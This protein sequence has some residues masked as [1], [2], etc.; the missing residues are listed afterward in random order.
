VGL[1]FWRRRG[2]GN[3]ICREEDGEVDG[4]KMMRTRDEQLLEIVY[5]LARLDR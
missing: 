2:G 5:V 3:T 4:E 1:P